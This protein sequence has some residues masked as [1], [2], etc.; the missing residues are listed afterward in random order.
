VDIIDAAN[1]LAAGKFDSGSPATWNQ[2]DFTYDGVVD[3]LD[4]ASFLSNGLFDAGVYNPPAGSVGAVAAVPE[5]SL[6][7]AAVVCGLGLTAL[8]GRRRG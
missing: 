2:G 5:P 8:R 6:W 7:A 4:A 1:F 3:I